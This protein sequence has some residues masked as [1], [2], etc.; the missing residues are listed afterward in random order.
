[1][2]VRPDVLDI[3][4]LDDKKTIP[5]TMPIIGKVFFTI[6][7]KK[8]FEYDIENAYCVDI[9]CVIK[10][11]EIEM[12]HESYWGFLRF[13]INKMFELFAQMIDTNSIIIE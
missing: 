9:Q 7:N 12:Y 10:V 4:T 6:V 13:K 8:K 11:T 2:R 3:I 5:I 1:M